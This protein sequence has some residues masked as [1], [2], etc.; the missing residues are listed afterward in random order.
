MATSMDFP[1][2]RSKKY[3]ENI[4]QNQDTEQNISFIAV[5]GPSG[6]RGPKGEKGDKGDKGDPGLD[7][8]QGQKG[9]RGL[10]GKDAVSALPAS[11]QKPGWSTYVNKDSFQA[12]LGADQGQDGWV[13]IT[14]STDKNESYLPEKRVSLW[15]DLT[16]KINLKALNLGSIITIRYDIE[17]TT[18]LNNTE[19]WVKT[20]CGEE[21]NS[22]TTF[23]GNLKY[24]FDYDISVEHT[25]FLSDEG[26]QSF[27][28]IPQIR[29]DNDASARLKSLYIAVR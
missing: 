18:F 6:E 15:N 27:G 7:G 12:R 25:L 5:P 23:V 22:S 17:L 4:K 9:D 11:N 24:Q 2:S 28:G 14:A 21:S 8:K 20:Y 26:M 16:Q 13:N 29:T 19:V 10:P 3:S 1:S